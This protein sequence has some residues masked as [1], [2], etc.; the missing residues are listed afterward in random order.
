VPRYLFSSHDGFGLGHVRRN[1]LIARALLARDQSAFA[2][3]VTGVPFPV[4]WIDRERFAGVR[5]PPLLKQSDGSYRNPGMDF[6]EAIARRAR[7]FADV[8]RSFD[9]D[10]VVVDRHPYGTGG[11]LREGLEL[12]RTRGAALVL[13]LRDIIDE[14]DAVVEEL[15][16]G[17][18]DDVAE[19]FRAAL[20]YGSRDVCD[21]EA[22]YALPL[23]PTYCGWVTD[24]PAGGVAREPRLL[25]IAGGGG[26]D[27]GKVFRLGAAV[28]E[29]RPGWRG[30]VAAGPYA[31]AESV[32]S[33]AEGPLRDRLEV[34]TETEGCT[35]L[36][37][38]AGAVLEMAGYNSTVEA[39]AAGHRPVLVPR[40][41]PRREQAIRAQRFAALGLADVLDENAAPGEVEWLLDQPRGLP[42]R[43]LEEAGISLDGATR[44]AA[45]LVSLART[46][47]AA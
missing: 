26:G 46:G 17:G 31:D 37:A 47:V 41:A 36:F 32:R 13:G 44:A 25:A 10:V 19:S 33:L 11:E 34:T 16:G 7:V 23:Q 4:P 6:E 20:V 24:R 38:R 2:V 30:Q 22:E 29:R 18:W 43:A 28:L 8:V 5:V 15:S 21:H 12:A 14:P 35:N 27:G 39:L 3:I 45:E 40:R 9:P 42:T 1:S